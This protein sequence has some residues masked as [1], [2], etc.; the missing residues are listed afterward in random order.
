MIVT[1]M[2][3]WWDEVESFF[4]LEDASGIRAL[5]RANG[6]GQSN[7]GDKSDGLDVEVI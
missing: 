2:G 7:E 4:S 1:D 3:R 6:V 5:G